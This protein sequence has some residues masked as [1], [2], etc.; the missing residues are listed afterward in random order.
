MKLKDLNPRIK[1]GAVDKLLIFD[2]PLRCPKQYGFNHTFMLPITGAKKWD[3]DSEDLETLT[4]RPSVL[5][6][7]S[8]GVHFYITA[9]KIEML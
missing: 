3:V 9:G 7:G 1:T 8:C 2:C 4:L 5:D 6:I